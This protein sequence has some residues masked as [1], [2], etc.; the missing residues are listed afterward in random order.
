LTRLEVEEAVAVALAEEL[1]EEVADAD[2]DDEGKTVSF[3]DLKEGDWVSTT[4]IEVTE[5][6]RKKV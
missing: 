1:E 6:I 3:P 5:K 2:V 4:D